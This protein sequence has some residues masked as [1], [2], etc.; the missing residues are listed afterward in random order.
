MIVRELL[1]LLG[2]TVDKASYDKAKKAYDSLQGSMAAQQRVG[3]NAAGQ[4]QKQGR[5]VADAAQQAAKGTNMLGQAL[6]MMQRF[7]AQAG[8]SGLLKQYTTL[9]SDANETFSALKELFG[10]EG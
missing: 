8:I 4:T 3:Q 6:G 7:A 2:F 10:E 9:A 5:A 1:T